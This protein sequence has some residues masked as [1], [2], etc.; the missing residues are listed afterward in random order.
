MPTIIVNRAT[1]FKA[2]GQ[3]FTDKEFDDLC[4]EF[5]IEL[6]DVTTEKDIVSSFYSEEYYTFL[7]GVYNEKVLYGVE[8]YNLRLLKTGTAT[9]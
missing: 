3:S 8:E 6:D 2:I 1:L 5:G 7:E 9:H 4:F